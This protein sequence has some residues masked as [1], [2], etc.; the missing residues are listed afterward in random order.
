MSPSYKIDEKISE[1]IVKNNTLCTDD[2]DKLELVIYYK[3]KITS[4]F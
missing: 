1:N 4:K 2:N 3:N